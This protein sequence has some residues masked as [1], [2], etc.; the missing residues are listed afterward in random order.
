MATLLYLVIPCYNEEQVLP[1]TAQR[2]RKKLEELRQRGVTDPRS[3]ICFVDD[4][5]KD[6]TWELIAELHEK[7]SVISG[8]KLSRNRGHQNALLCGLMTLKDRAE[9][10][11]S[12]DA[13]LQDDIDAIDGMLEKFAA[14]CD[15]VYGVRMDRKTDGALKRMTAEGYYRLLKRMGAEVVFNHADFRLLSRRALD[16]LAEYGEVNLFLRGIVPMLGFKSDVVYYARAERFAGKSKY[17]PKK[18]LGLAWEGITSLSIRPIRIVTALGAVVTLAGLVLFLLLL[19]WLC[20]GHPRPDWGLIVAS[21]WTVGGLQMVAV[22]VVGEYV[23][24]TYL[25]SKARP[26]YITECVLDDRA[27]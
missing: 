18:M 3:R 2:L 22:G 19:I 13:D 15:V 12:M 24:K 8:I 11:I 23:G 17:S 20:I 16:A 6:R 1:V 14:G 10:I 5:S 9:C 21:V 4:G 26:R 7:D 25:E 27:S